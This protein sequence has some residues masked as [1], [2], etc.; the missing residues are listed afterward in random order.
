MGCRSSLCTDPNE[1]L[2]SSQHGQDKEIDITIPVSE[3]STNQSLTALMNR[4]SRPLDSCKSSY[5]LKCLKILLPG[6]EENNEELLSLGE[7]WISNIYK[8]L[9]DL[10]VMP[11]DLRTFISL[12]SSGNTLVL[13]HEVDGIRSFEKIA[14]FCQKIQPIVKKA[15]LEKFKYKHFIKCEE[16]L[17]SLGPLTISAYL[18][19]GSEIDCGIGI[20]KPLDRRQMS[21][22]ISVS[23][24]AKNIATWC[25]SNGQPIPV[26][27]A[28]S[29]LSNKKS[30]NFYVFDGLR[31]Q[32]FSRGFSM[33]I[34]FGAPIPEKLQ[35][36]MEEAKCDE[37]NC[38]LGFDDDCISSMSM[39]TKA[40]NLNASFLKD[41]EI[42]FNE[43]KWEQFQTMFSVK[44]FSL[45]LSA[46]GFFIVQQALI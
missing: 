9:E 28:F 2:I 43:K 14:W 6:P 27:C 16:F 34:H 23:S 7:L 31:T 21:Q 1:L 12:E 3:K 46:E 45:D 10:V 41:L 13:K 4:N 42:P 44:N 37:V 29:T 8:S 40:Y 5:L 38:I 30:M 11:E 20:E 26:S 24:E 35:N 39:M 18:K 36:F 33:F 25:N 32:N 17:M 19:L 15:K 22:F